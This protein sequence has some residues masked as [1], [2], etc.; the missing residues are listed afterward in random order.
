MK[1][2]NRQT[3]VIETE[4][5]HTM[6][7]AT[8]GSGKSTTLSEWLFYLLTVKKIPMKQITVPVSYTH[9]TLPT[10]DLV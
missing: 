10:S 4:S 2:D 3:S 1:F 8:P 6:V 7:P 9:L 5:R